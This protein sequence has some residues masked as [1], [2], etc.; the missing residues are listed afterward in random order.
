[1]DI[2]KHIVLLMDRKEITNYGIYAGRSFDT[3]DRKDTELF[4]MIRKAGTAFKDEDAIKLL[5]EGKKRTAYF[6]LKNRIVDDIN[7]SAFLLSFEENNN[8]LCL[9][10]LSMGY[11]YYN[12]SDFR[13]AYYQFKKA[14]KKAIEIESYSLLD[15]IYSRLIRVSQELS[16]PNTEEFIRKRVENKK[17]LD[18]LSQLDNVLEAVE[19][20]M[21]MSQNL[22]AIENIQEL[23]QI[24]IDD[25]AS[26][27][28]LKNSP[29]LQ[30]G[31]YRTVR[32]I[33]LQ[34]KDYTSLEAYLINTFTDFEKK[35]FFTRNNHDTKLEMLSW[36]ANTLFANKKYNQSLE[37]TALMHTEMQKFDSIFYNRYEIFYY[38]CLVINY[39][40][41]NPQKA[42]DTLLHLT[43]KENKDKMRLYGV[44]V[45]LN[46]ALLYYQQRNYSKSLDN[47]MKMYKHEGFGA[48]DK[49]VQLK[50]NLGE[51]ILRYELK[52]NEVAEYRLKQIEKDF[53][54]ALEKNDRWE[55][56][57]LKLI[58]LMV[59]GD[60]YKKNK[61][62]N[63]TMKNFTDK[64]EAPS[65][66]DELFN[67]D[68]WL[69]EKA[70]L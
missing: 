60:N 41:I 56:Y 20:R 38:N 47:I 13:M 48:T 61:E 22:S 55:K 68:K 28:E 3:T 18:K 43:Q 2:L 62:F 64:F 14:E 42:I 35:K 16:E 40:V 11:Y 9:Y 45:Y 51:L 31:I 25:F 63:A 52:E 15:I 58:S 27:E 17:I 24:T 69:K 7:K 36:I 34:K 46:L 50:M 29:L 1:M 33:L 10:L 26:D 4:R 59:R 21:K 66:G 12:K 70:N 23:L 57:F 53:A 19:Y 6:R 39:S 37:Y 32:N 49:M 8:M 67:Y 54:Q 5:Y 65:T 44:F 30:T